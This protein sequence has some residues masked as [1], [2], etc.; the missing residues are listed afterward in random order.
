MHAYSRYI[1]VCVHIVEYK[2]SLLAFVHVEATLLF[3][4]ILRYISI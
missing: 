1:H 3:A 2:D 4:H